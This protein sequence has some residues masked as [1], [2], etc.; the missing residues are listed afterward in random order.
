MPGLIVEGVARLHN[1]TSRHAPASFQ[2]QRFPQPKSFR[3]R[4]RRR[5]LLRTTAGGWA[6]CDQRPGRDRS[7][8]PYAPTLYTKAERLQSTGP[9]SSQPIRATTVARP[10]SL[11]GL[12]CSAHRSRAPR[13]KPYAYGSMLCNCQRHVGREWAPL[14]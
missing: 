8:R 7:E 12:P 14:D 9:T 3:P 4:A 1:T 6:D 11:S 10:R 13:V 2:D 5:I